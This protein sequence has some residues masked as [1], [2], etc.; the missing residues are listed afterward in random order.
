MSKT[1]SKADETE[2]KVKK[3]VLGRILKRRLAKE[4]KALV[5]E[6][7][8][9]SGFRVEFEEDDE[10][11][12][13]VYMSGFNEQTILYKS[14]KEKD[15]KELHIEMIIPINFPMAPPFIRIVSPRMC[16]WNG[17]ISNGGTLCLD[18]L[19]DEAWSPSMMLPILLVSLQEF[20][21]TGA[22][23]DKNGSYTLEEA[24]KGYKYTTDVHKWGKIHKLH[25]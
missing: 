2:T 22:V 24:K 3:P 4:K 9:K 1:D 19:T 10:L 23:S 8:A 13:H 17:F 12:I 7:F 5:E 18:T 21:N 20:M 11:I 16:N 25:K 15:V 14:M 6:N